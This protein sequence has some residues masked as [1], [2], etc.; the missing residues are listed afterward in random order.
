MNHWTLV[1]LVWF[2]AIIN[3]HV[4]MSLYQRKVEK[5][6]GRKVFRYIT[7]WDYVQGLLTLVLFAPAVSLI[8]CTETGAKAMKQMVARVVAIRPENNVT[9]QEET[10]LLKW[11]DE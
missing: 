10:T 9:K 4:V 8:L 6:L 3:S 5:L 11:A 1:E 7:P 2:A